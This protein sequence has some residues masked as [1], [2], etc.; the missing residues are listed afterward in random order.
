MDI[1][2][3]CLI[4]TQQYFG[5]VHLSGRRLDGDLRMD[6]SKTCV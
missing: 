3:M 2:W 5:Q 4:P 6:T 1:R